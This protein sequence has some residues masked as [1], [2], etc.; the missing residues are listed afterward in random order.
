M[1]RADERMGAILKIFSFLAV[2]IACLGL[3]GLAS[4]TAEQRTKEIGVRKVLGASST[5]IVTL[6]SKEFSKWVLLANAL[7]WP[8]AYLVTRSWLTGFAYRTNAAWWLFAAAGVGAFA[9][10]LI[11]VG[12]QAV[13]AARSNPVDCLKYE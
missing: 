10:A 11:T 8:A 6:L 4:F 12:F 5:G 9:V 7:A 2:A 13:R 1:Y 3:F